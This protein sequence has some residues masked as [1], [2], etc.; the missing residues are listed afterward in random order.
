MLSPLA[1]TPR[2]TAPSRWVET[3]IH[4]SLSLGADPST[5]PTTLNGRTWEAAA[6][7]S[8]LRVLVAPSSTDPGYRCGES[9]ARTSP[10]D[11]RSPSRALASEP[12]A[13]AHWGSGAG[14][15]GGPS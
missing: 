10:G 5:S 7:K 13:R 1:V 11:T 6:E 14:G 4:S 8:T 9:A 3:V 2:P 12:W 15:K